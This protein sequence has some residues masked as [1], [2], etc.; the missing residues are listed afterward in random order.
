MDSV[1]LHPADLFQLH[2]GFAVVIGKRFDDEPDELS[3]DSD[4]RSAAF[5]EISVYPPGHRPGLFM[6]FHKQRIV[7][8]D[9]Y[10]RGRTIRG[11]V[12]ELGIARFALPFDNTFLQYPQ[13]HDV[14]EKVVPAESAGLIGELVLIGCVGCDGLIPFET[15]DRPGSAAEKGVLPAPSHGVRGTLSVMAG[16]GD[17]FDVVV[18]ADAALYHVPQASHFGT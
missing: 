12:D 5:F 11:C 4:G 18:R 16:G 9:E 13:A 8:V 2:D 6:G 14:F 1:E 17:E 10:L 3:R 15:D 7:D